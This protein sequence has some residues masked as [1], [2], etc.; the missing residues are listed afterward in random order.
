MNN[1]LDT[2]ISLLRFAHRVR[3]EEAEQRLYRYSG[4]GL[5]AS[6]MDDVF[7]QSLEDGWFGFTKTAYS[8]SAMACMAAVLLLFVTGSMGQGTYIDGIVH[9]FFDDPAGLFALYYM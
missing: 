8:F 2:F 9:G 1:R 7:F 6:V 4:A 3:Q 5:V